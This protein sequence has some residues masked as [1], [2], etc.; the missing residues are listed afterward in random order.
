MSPTEPYGLGA[1]L[2]IGKASIEYQA[3]ERR[4]HPH[5]IRIKTTP[6]KKRNTQAIP[7]SSPKRKKVPPYN[8]N[9]NDPTLKKA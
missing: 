8:P 9:K 6:K 2:L 5:I 4:K 3:T 1:K 7:P